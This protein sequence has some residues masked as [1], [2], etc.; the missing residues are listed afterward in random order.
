MSTLQE[1]RRYAIICSHISEE[2]YPILYA[3]RDESK[4]ES[5]SGWQFLCNS[6][7]QED[8]DNAQ[9]WAV[10]EVISKEA[11]LSQFIDFPVGTELL[12]SSVRKPWTVKTKK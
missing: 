8:V 9:I 4:D 11:S 1:D 12:R 2:N 7:M 10:D 5:D 3:F 6:G